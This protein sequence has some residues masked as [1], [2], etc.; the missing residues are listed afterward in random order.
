MELVYPDYYTKFRCIA[1]ACPDSCC[2]GWA[3]AVDEDSARYYRSIPGELGDVLR[4]HLTQEDGD[5]V[6]SL[7][8][9]GR[10]PMWQDDGLCRLQCLMGEKA[11]CQTCRDFPR[12][13]HDYGSFMELGLELSCPEAARL[14]L[15]GS[16]TVIQKTVP[17]GEVP[18]YDGEAMRILLESR[19]NLLRFL[20]NDRFGAGETLAVMLLYGCAVQA[21]LDGGEP[22]TLVPEKTLQTAVQLAGEGNGEAVL[23]FFRKLEILTPQWR[24][25]LAAPEGSCWQ[26]I[27]RRIARYGVERYWLQAVSD[28][29]LVGRVKLIAAFCLVVKLLGG[30]PISTAQLCSKEIEN[31]ADNV[32][33]ILDGAYTA[34]ALT[35]LNLLGLLLG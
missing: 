27:H 15:S 2:Q 16:H 23:D 21:W 20:E 34:P 35:D 13:R 29:D 9:D 32:D 31:D 12:L 4:E 22:A 10:C 30:D 25:R 6:L 14:I 5:T 11:L 7:T 8:A 28:Y 17:G 18:E 3:V 19:E 24:H 26:E 1:G 33:A